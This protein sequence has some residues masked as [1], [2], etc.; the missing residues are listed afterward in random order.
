M[1][2]GVISSNPTNLINYEG[3]NG[4]EEGIKKARQLLMLSVNALDKQIAKK[5]DMT[6]DGDRYCPIASCSEY[7]ERTYKY[8]PE[9]GHKLDWD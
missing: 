7:V 9:C 3:V 4:M 5:P 6:L 1:W 8:C 2:Q